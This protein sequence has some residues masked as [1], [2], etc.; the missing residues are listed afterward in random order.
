MGFSIM[1]WETEAPLALHQV[2]KVRE[3]D[4]GEI[5]FTPQFKTTYVLEQDLSP[6]SLP[7]VEWWNTAYTGT[8]R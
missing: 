7:T 8:W 2:V 3:P 5:H 4:F 6:T 1:E